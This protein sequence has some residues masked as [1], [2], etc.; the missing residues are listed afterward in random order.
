[1]AGSRLQKILPH[2]QEK[3]YKPHGSR[4]RSGT[5]EGL[6]TGELA[7]EEALLDGMC[8]WAGPVVGL[9]L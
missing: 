4:L 1:M 7:V 3:A 8:R 9:R 6:I 2:A 5:G